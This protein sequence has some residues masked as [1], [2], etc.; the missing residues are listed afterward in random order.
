MVRDGG[1]FGAEPACLVLADGTV[2]H[3]EALAAAGV[4]GVEAAYGEVVFNT[5][6]TGYQEV[7]S[8]PSYAGQI[9]VMTYPHIGNYGANPDDDEAARVAA[10]GLVVRDVSR[11]ASNHRAAETFDAW[12]RRQGV[13]AITGVD[14][15][16]LTRHIRSVGAMCGGIFTGEL[17]SGAVDDLVDR[18][19]AEP[20]M[21]GRNLVTEVTCPEPYESPFEPGS[22]AFRVHL[23][24]YGVKRTILRRLAAQG[25]AV[26]VFPAGTPPAALLDGGPDGV[27]LSNGPGDPAAVTGAREQVAALLGRVPVFGICLGHQILS[28]VLGAQSEKLPFGHHGANH[29]VMDLATQR[30]EITSQNHGFNITFENAETTSAGV[31]VPEPA[32]VGARRRSDAGAERVETELGAV[33]VTHRNLNDGTLE[34]IRCLEI[35]AFSVQY[36]PEAGPGPRD[37]SHLFAHFC[38]LMEA[39]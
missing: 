15:R 8:D 21:E 4:A 29:P 3:G 19:R 22:R 28:L 9:V 14:T 18:V 35:P 5:A 16:R 12:L 37:A 24:D 32:F 6:L 33:E 17:A 27:M 10:K 1:L 11:V 23:V 26:T 13:T 2:F 38:E 25:C 34:G 7:L 30:V 20:G 39:G 31:A 36:H